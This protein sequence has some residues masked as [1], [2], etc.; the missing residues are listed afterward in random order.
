MIYPT[1]NGDMIRRIAKEMLLV[2]SRLRLSLNPREEDH[3][4]L[5]EK[6]E[7][8][9]HDVV[10]EV[11]GIAKHEGDWLRELTEE[12]ITLSQAILKRE[13]ERVKAGD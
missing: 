2:S 6:L 13:W 1:T 9:V 12:I 11:T 3:R 8:L 5:M 7:K 4:Q 10:D